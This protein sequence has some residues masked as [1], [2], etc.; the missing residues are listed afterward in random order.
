[1]RFHLTGASTAHSDDA[2]VGLLDCN[3]E[4]K[5]DRQCACVGFTLIYCDTHVLVSMTSGV[6]AMHIGL[7]FGPS[8]IIAPEPP[9]EVVVGYT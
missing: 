4:S 8:Q 2:R 6:V 3:E 9:A 7:M 1:M 5:T